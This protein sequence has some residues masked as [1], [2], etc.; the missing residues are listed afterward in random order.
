MSKRKSS[1]ILVTLLVTLFALTAWAVIPAIQ[2]GCAHARGVAKRVHT[3]TLFQQFY[4]ELEKRKDPDFPKTREELLTMLKRANIDWNS[5]SLESG[6]VLDG[7]KRPIRIQFNPSNSVWTFAS[8]GEDGEFETGDDLEFRSE[9]RWQY[10]SMII[11]PN[12]G[13]PVVVD[14]PDGYKFVH[15]KYGMGAAIYSQ[16]GSEFKFDFGHGP[17]KGRIEKWRHGEV[18]APYIILDEVVKNGLGSGELMITNHIQGD[19][20]YA[21]FEGEP[22]YKVQGYPVGNSEIEAFKFIVKSL[23][24]HKSEESDD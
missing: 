16:A 20:H 24:F 21:I 8:A 10:E 3:G 18:M 19:R 15:S 5:C 7:W 22:G 13:R 6:Q 2:S 9:E 12:A 17:H 11:G 14:V 23:R 1:P 4:A